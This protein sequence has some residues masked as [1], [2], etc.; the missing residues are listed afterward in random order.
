VLC[1]SLFACAVAAVRIACEAF[2]YVKGALLLSPKDLF[3]IKNVKRS[4]S[5]RYTKISEHPQKT[6][7]RYQNVSFKANTLKL[8]DIAGA[9]LGSC[10]K[11]VSEGM[12]FHLLLCATYPLHYK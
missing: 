12:V 3:P 2:L 4:V 9:F 6:A 8:A 7:I 1:F 10:R 11:N 5:K